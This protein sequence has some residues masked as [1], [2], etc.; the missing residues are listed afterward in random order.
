MGEKGQG[1]G[2]HGCTRE[3]QQWR[4]ALGLSGWTLTGPVRALLT[5]QSLN[6]RIDSITGF[7]A[8]GVCGSTISA[9]FRPSMYCALKWLWY[10][11]RRG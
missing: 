9:P 2:C 3:S 10:C 4:P 1:R 7:A 6:W 8:G 5:H 11:R